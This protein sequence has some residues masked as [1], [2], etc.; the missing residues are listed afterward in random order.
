PAAGEDKD[1]GLV[2][3]SAGELIGESVDRL[4]DRLV[5]GLVVDESVLVDA[6]E[7][8]DMDGCSLGE[9][10]SLRSRRGVLDRRGGCDRV[11]A[12]R[13][14]LTAL[15]SSRC[16]RIGRWSRESG[17]EQQQ[18]APQDRGSVLR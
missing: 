11:S 2:D 7:V 1:D 13:A 17:C 18:E 6:A 5:D 10:I 3:G 8:A 9:R 4:V 16:H 15:V 14:A 12:P